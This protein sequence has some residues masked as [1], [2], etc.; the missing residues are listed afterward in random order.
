M[1]GILDIAL[2]ILG[3]LFAFAGAVLLGV[4]IA[5]LEKD[6]EQTPDGVEAQADTRLIGAATAL[7]GAGA[8]LLSVGLV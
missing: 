7:A 5:Q 2:P 4:G 8:T 1:A 6:K 3:V